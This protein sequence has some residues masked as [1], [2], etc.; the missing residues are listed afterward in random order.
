MATTPMIS[1]MR[2]TVPAISPGAVG[3][4]LVAHPVCGAGIALSIQ[5]GLGAAPWDVFH[6]GLHRATGLSIGVATTATAVAAVLVALAAGVRP[7]WGTLVNALLIGACV[8]LA[9][10]L[11]PAAPS[12]PLA[13]GYLAAAIVLIGL[14]TGLYLG[15]RLGSG[16]RDSLMVALARRPRWTISSARV[17]IE[18]GALGAG[19]LLGGPL[20]AGTVL[21]ALTIGPVTRWGIEIFGPGN[22][23]APCH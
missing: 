12:V 8:D 17:T 11:V 3:R 6:I 18:L 13:A 7:G 1:G 10:A 14:G 16:P 20:G 5:S 4:L 22:V 19:L 9:L 21:Y 2:S 23:E 15:A